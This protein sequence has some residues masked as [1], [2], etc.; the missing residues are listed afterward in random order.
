MPYPHRIADCRCV[1]AASICQMR[2]LCDV[3]LGARDY[4]LPIVNVMVYAL[5][6]WAPLPEPVGRTSADDVVAGRTSQ[7]R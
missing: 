7:H 5:M 2:S 6:S 4:Y 3:I 1:K